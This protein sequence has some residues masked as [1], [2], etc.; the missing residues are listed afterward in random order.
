MHSHTFFKVEVKIFPLVNIV[1]KEDFFDQAPQGVT[2]VVNN[3]VQT[4]DVSVQSQQRDKI[5]QILSHP[6]T[7]CWTEL[8]RTYAVGSSLYLME[9]SRCMQAGQ[10]ITINKKTSL[11][12]IFV[13]LNFPP[14]SAGKHSLI[15][16]QNRDDAYFDL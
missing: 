4:S 9:Q 5:H 1:L 12:S 2:L 11:I 14:T 15:P 7:F 8:P 3:V 6:H 13:Y 10:D 16:L